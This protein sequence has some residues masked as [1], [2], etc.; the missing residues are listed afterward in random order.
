LNVTV[1]FIDA[2]EMKVV[3]T[4]TYSHG[5]ENDEIPDAGDYLIIGSDSDPDRQGFWVKNVSLVSVARGILC[6]AVVEPAG[7]RGPGRLASSRIFRADRDGRLE[8]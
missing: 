4:Q 7:T 5:T 2:D 1:I 8:G 3:L 6:L